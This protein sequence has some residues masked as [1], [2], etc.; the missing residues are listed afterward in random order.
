[1]ARAVALPVRGEVFL[2][3]RDAGRALRAS[4]H[5]E[6]DLVVLPLRRGHTCTGTFQL[7]ADE[8]L[9]FV[10]ALADGLTEG[11]E[12]GQSLPPRAV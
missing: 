2:D 1:M 12:G 8:V 5:H 4:W 9:A 7:A 11:Y 3:A 10:H 6:D